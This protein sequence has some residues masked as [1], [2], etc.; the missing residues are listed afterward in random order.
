MTAASNERRAKRGRRDRATGTR[1]GG[2]QGEQGEGSRGSRLERERE[3]EKVRESGEES[4]VAFLSQLQPSRLKRRGSVLP[5]GEK[6]QEVIFK[7]TF[8]D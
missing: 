7:N 6:S 4:P 2:T 3:R 8:R 1:E 5:E